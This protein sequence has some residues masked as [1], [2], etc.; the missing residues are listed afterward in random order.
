[1]TAARIR[2]IPKFNPRGHVALAA[3]LGM[4]TGL[5]DQLAVPRLPAARVVGMDHRAAHDRRPLLALLVACLHDQPAHPAGALDRDYW[6]GRGLHD[7][8]SVSA[9]QIL[10]RPQYVTTWSWNDWLGGSIFALAFVGAAVLVGLIVHAV[11]RL[12]I[13]TFIENEGPVCY[14]CGYDTRGLTAQLCPE[15]GRSITDSRPRWR[16]LYRLSTFINRRGRQLGAVAFLAT[17]AYFTWQF[18][19]TTLPYIRFNSMFGEH[20]FRGGLAYD[21]APYSRSRPM[22]SAAVSWEPLRDA[23]PLGVGVALA[24]S[25]LPRDGSTLLQIWVS[26]D[27][28]WKSGTPMVQYVSCAACAYF[29]PA[30]AN[31]ILARGIPQPLIDALVRRYREAEAE[32]GPD[33]TEWTKEYL[34]D[35]EPF[36]PK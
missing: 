28:Q 8:L 21:C 11:T 6:R 18:A 14:H 1:M 25:D 34:V 24:D 26:K 10:L 23:Y 5:F 3:S 7:L 27:P 31:S 19:S 2:V 35:P 12:F 36:L 30:Q 29:D 9:T 16:W 20:M 33:A 32:N 17:M 4:L 22:Y 13:V 15:C